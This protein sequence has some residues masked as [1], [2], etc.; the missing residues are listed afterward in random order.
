MMKA[1]V[2]HSA[3]DRPYVERVSRRYEN[4]GE[5]VGIHGPGLNTK[6]T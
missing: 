6:C 2:A 3:C 5:A 4:H 1:E